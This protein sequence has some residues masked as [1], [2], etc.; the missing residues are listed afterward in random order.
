M[1]DGQWSVIDPLLPD[2]VSLHGDG[3]PE[4]WC[5]RDIVD[6]IFYVVDNGG[7]WRALPVDFPPWP[8]VY[9][10]LACWEKHGI[11]QRVLDGLRDRVR[12]ADGRAAEP[13][14]ALTPGSMAAFSTFVAARDE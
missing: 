1:T 8:T 11:T 7:K 6:A 9:R 3:R 10:Y 14:A 13:S 12:I 2:P 4:E 5:R